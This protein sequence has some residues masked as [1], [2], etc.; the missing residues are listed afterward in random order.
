MIMSGSTPCMQV[1]P[2]RSVVFVL[3][4][5]HRRPHEFLRPL[6]TRETNLSMV[7]TRNKFGLRIPIQLLTRMN[8]LV[9][10]RARA[11]HT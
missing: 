11:T 10:L 3:I 6:I 5:C 4:M 9:S 1:S 8:Q 2:I 7:R